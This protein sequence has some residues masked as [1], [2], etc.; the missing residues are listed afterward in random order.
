MTTADTRGHQREE[1]HDSSSEDTVSTSESPLHEM[2]TEFGDI[3]DSVD[4]VKTL[5]DK[6]F[7]RKQQ[8]IIRLLY[9]FFDWKTVFSLNQF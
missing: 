1:M 9:K 6:W 2:Q 3:S 4:N 5:L 8:L 7:H